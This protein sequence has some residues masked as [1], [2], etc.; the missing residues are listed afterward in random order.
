MTGYWV[1]LTGRFHENTPDTYCPVR[2]FLDGSVEIVLGLI[3]LGK[4]E[5]KIIGEFNEDTKKLSVE[6]KNTK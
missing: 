2:L 6:A 1:R 4:P 3:Y 5:G